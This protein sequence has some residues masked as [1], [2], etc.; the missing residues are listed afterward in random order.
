MHA[1]FCENRRIHY[2]KTHR[3][4]GTID[5]RVMKE[6]LCHMPIC[7]RFVDCR[8]PYCSNVRQIM[9]HLRFCWH[10]PICGTCDIIFSAQ[11]SR[12][13]KDIISH[14]RCYHIFLFMRVYRHVYKVA[15]PVLPKEKGF[16]LRSKPLML[17]ACHCDKSTCVQK[18]C[19]EFKRAIKHVKE[20]DSLMSQRDNCEIAM[21][22]YIDHMKVCSDPNCNLLDAFRA[23]NCWIC[24]FGRL[25][26]PL[27]FAQ[28]EN[29]ICD[30]R[31]VVNDW[32]WKNVRKAWNE[33]D[34]LIMADNIS[35]I[36]F[37]YRELYLT[38]FLDQ[39]VVLESLSFPI[40]FVSSIP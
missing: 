7:K 31:H 25:S 12:R 15:D 1:L 35:L 3:C 17:H 37:A 29:R 20:C 10:Q 23:R 11:L 34:D 19:T 38:L 14:Y 6:V 21:R 22:L 13:G 9:V 30:V 39:Q 40:A 8:I 16:L 27:F 24:L 33:R 28:R 36:T 32:G 2:T 4:D 5:C 26:Y 18:Y